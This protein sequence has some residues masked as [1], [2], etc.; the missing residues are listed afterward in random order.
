MSLNPQKMW[1]QG[2]PL[3]EA[4]TCFWGFPNHETDEQAQKDRS[5]YLLLGR[6]AEQGEV[7]TSDRGWQ[8]YQPES[9]EHRREL[10]EKLRK[11]FC[12]NLCN[13]LMVGKLIASGKQIKPIPSTTPEIISSTE[14]LT[15]QERQPDEVTVAHF[16]DGGVRSHYPSWDEDVLVGRTAEFEQVRVLDST[17]QIGSAQRQAIADPADPGGRPTERDTILTAFDQCLEKGNI[18]SK[19]TQKTVARTVQDHIRREMSDYWR[20]D[21][22]KKPGSGYSVKTIT[23]HIKDRFN[24]LKNKHS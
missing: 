9:M 8:R 1:E 10:R 14:I 6:A 23:R 22:S 7:D 18:D 13:Q 15:E 19:D 21:E 24:S 5:D 11:A 17:D 16:L 4:F 20:G 2:V 3:R 12:D